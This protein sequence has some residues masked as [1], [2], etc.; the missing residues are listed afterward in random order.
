MRPC[1]RSS[2]GAWWATPTAKLAGH[3]KSQFDPAYEENLKPLSHWLER[4]SAERFRARARPDY[5]SWRAA[6]QQQR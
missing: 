5:F 2:R 1:C 4:F 6:Q 3:Q